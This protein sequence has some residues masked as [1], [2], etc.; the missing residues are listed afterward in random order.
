MGERDV[1]VSSPVLTLF[2]RMT[3][4]R[5]GRL[6]SGNTVDEIRYRGGGPILGALGYDNVAARRANCQFWLDEGTGSLSD[7]LKGLALALAASGFGG[8]SNS[9]VRSGV[10]G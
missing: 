5:A 3:R 7:E 10:A 9:G 6:Y 2:G 8:R 4:K 1:I